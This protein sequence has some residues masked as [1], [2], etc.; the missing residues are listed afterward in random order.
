MRNTLYRFISGLTRHT[1][2]DIIKEAEYYVS[3]YLP[4]GSGFNGGS[5]LDTDKTTHE[6]LVFAT[7]FQHMNDH[8]YYTRWTEH[9]VTVTPSFFGLNIKVSGRNHRDI[10]EYVA[11]CFEHVLN[12]EV[13][14]GLRQKY[15]EIV[16]SNAA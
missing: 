5:R 3:Q 15:I 10:K 14:D 16:R 11:E 2:S 6:K 8:G 1:N 4:S 9:T 7:S 12:E 13:G